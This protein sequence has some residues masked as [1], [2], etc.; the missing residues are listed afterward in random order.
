MFDRTLP[1]VVPYVSEN[2]S[3]IIA[4]QRKL[5]FREAVN[6]NL[7]DGDSFRRVMDRE[8]WNNGTGEAKDNEVQHEGRSLPNVL[9]ALFAVREHFLNVLGLAIE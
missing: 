7:L 6:C 4:F 5:E 1:H 2:D 8:I 9:L 3:S